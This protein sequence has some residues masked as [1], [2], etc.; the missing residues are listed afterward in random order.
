MDNVFESEARQFR[1]ALTVAAM[2]LT[3]SVCDADP[4]LFVDK[5]HSAR[6]GALVALEYD[7]FVPPLERRKTTI[8]GQN[9]STVPHA[10]DMTGAYDGDNRFAVKANARRG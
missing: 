10:V 8:N 9:K 3:P 7:Q 5:S 2:L 6:A 1:C 4:I